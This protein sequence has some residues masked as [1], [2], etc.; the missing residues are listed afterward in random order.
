MKGVALSALLSGCSGLPSL[1]GRPASST[2]PTTE[3]ADTRLGRATAPQA[4]AHPGQ[5]GVLMLAQGREAFATRMLLADAAERSLDVQV[6]IWHADLTGTLLMQAM[7]AAADRGVRVLFRVS[8][9]GGRNIGNEYFGAGQEVSFVDMDV[10][11]TGALVPQVSADFD[12]QW[13]S[14]SAYPVA[15]LR[16]PAPP[17]ALDHMTALAEALARSPSAAPY[18]TALEQSTFLKQLVAGEPP[19]E[20]T[21]V[22]LVSDDPAKCPSQYGSHLAVGRPRLPV[23][24][25]GRRCPR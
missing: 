3:T 2:L 4:Q 14:A 13:A 9:V 19:L 24:G 10:L 1:D 6:Y 17:R 21:T 5:S 25:Q 7:R 16:P 11:V 20:W 15:T 23:V 8:I 18:I 22:R 12:R